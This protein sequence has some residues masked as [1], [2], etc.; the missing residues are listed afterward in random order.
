MIRRY[1]GCI[2]MEALLLCA[3]SAGQLPGAEAKKLAYPKAPTSGQ[4]DDYHGIKV[5][6]PYRPLEDVDSDAVRTWVDAENKLTLDYL[7]EI[8]ARDQIRSRMK[9]LLQYER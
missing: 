4:V 6:D 3:A 9:E 2:L 5:A 8:P 7:R 1:L